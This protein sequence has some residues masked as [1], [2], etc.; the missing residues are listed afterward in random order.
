MCLDSLISPIIDH[1]HFKSFLFVE[2]FLLYTMYQNGLFDCQSIEVAHK[3]V[4]V[5]ICQIDS[6]CKT[7][8]N[9]AVYFSQWK[10]FVQAPIS[11]SSVR[12]IATVDTESKANMQG[13]FNQSNFNL[14]LIIIPIWWRKKPNGFL[15]KSLQIKFSLDA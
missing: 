7:A 6:G 12:Q 4:L 2:P 11:N 9:A 10:M 15:S 3:N 5:T 13:A 8:K 1:L 14:G